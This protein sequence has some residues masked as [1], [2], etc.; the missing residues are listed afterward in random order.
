MAQV[1]VQMITP[2]MAN[3]ILSS[4]A[5]D[6]QRNI[7]PTW[8]RYLSEE[9]KSGSF[10]QDTSI[11]F[12]KLPQNGKAT[13]IDGYHRL[14]AVINSGVATRFVVVETTVNSSDEMDRLYY[15]IDQGKRRTV[16][17]QLRVLDFESEYDLTSTQLRRLASA[18]ALIDAGWGARTIMHFDDRE[19]LVRE[20][21]QEC[22]H[23]FAVTSGRRK[24]MR[25][26]FERSSTLS[27]GLVT[28]K[29]SVKKYGLE[30]IEEFWEGVATNDGLAANDSRKWAYEH[31]LTAA[32]KGGGGGPM[33]ANVMYTARYSA[34]YI[35]H[36]F[37]LFV[38]NKT[39]RQR[40][41]I[42]QGAPMLILGS[43]FNGK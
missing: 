40:P 30:K 28:L 29:Y 31:L 14:N 9:M 41:S 42:D 3:D 34:K 16:A 13:L 7:A 36:C 35:A 23:Y 1:S 11:E 39:L 26:S 38:Q 25:V 19:K 20:Y 43:P 8:M 37:N 17:D 15:R 18:I 2:S 27:V 12:V 24:E 32:I 5:Y 10:K 33:G 6:K 21:A 4:Q 22:G